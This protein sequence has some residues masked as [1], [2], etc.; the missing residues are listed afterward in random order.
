MIVTSILTKLLSV[1][2]LSESSKN[3][4]DNSV[5]LKHDPT[6]T[7][8]YGTYQGYYNAS[9]DMDVWR[10]IRYAAPPTGQWRWRAP[11]PPQAESS[12]EVIDARDW[13]KQCTESVPG[14]GPSSILP[15]GL[16]RLLIIID[17]EDRILRG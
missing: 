9:T 4:N 14:V 5:A 12:N 10:S 7:L 1:L 15:F 6:V 2:G 17:R 8:P 3:G 11:Q 16:F 13:P